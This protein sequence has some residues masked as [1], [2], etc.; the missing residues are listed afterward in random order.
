MVW[1]DHPVVSLTQEGL[2]MKWI[3]HSP[4]GVVFDFSKKSI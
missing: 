2:W 4:G 1:I 3:L